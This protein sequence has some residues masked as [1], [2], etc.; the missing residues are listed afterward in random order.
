M[1]PAKVVLGQGEGTH[2]GGFIVIPWKL[3][4]SAL[5]PDNGGELRL[6]QRGA[7][8]SIRA[9]G[10]ELMNSRVHASE[11]ALA[12]LSCRPIGA[13]RKVR[14]L[15][16]GLGMGFTLAATLRVLRADAQV[17]VAELVPAVVAWNRTHLGHLAGF[18]LDDPRVVVREGDVANLLRDERDAYD[19]ILLDVDNGPEGFTRAANDWLY[20]RDGLRHARGALREQGV[21]GVWSAGADREFSQR[22]RQTG[23]AVEEVMF[24]ARGRRGGSRHHIWLATR[25]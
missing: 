7:E 17:V 11:E 12:E 5:I 23:F 8:L 3:L 20:A 13:R 4:D 6:Y 1:V 18:P 2:N 19:A 15:V 10:Q 24:K 9:D 25:P 14:V 21:L 16:G 22:L